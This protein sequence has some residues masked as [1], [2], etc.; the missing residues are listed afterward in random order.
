MSTCNIKVIARFRPLNENEKKKKDQANHSEF[1]FT[2]SDGKR[3]DLRVDKTVHNFSFDASY[4]VD[5]KQ[6]SQ[7]S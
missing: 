7:F 1:E 3:V 6:V 5:C 4:D 2:I